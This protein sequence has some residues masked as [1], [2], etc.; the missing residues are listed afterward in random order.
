[1]FVI[2]KINPPRCLSPD[3]YLP[4]SSR[5]T[6]VQD[7]ED[8]M[9]IEDQVNPME[10]DDTNNIVEPDDG[11]NRLIQDIFAPIDEE[12]DDDIYDVPLLE[13]EEQP[14]YEGSRTNI[15]SAIMLL[16]NLKVLNGLSNTCLTQI[17]RYVI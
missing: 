3:K 16:V 2:V 7:V 8:G 6:I 15:L 17:L 11:T 9:N 12:N 5:N 10:E 13:K 1:L 4:S 14:L